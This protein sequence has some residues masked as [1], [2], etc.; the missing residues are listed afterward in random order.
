MERYVRGAWPS[1]NAA[2]VHPVVEWGTFRYV[3]RKSVSLARSLVAIL[4][5]PVFLSHC[6]TF[7]TIFSANPLVAGW[8]G[9]DL[10]SC[11]DRFLS[12]V[13]G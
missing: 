3:R 4:L 11:P 1:S 8:Y 7:L 5:P 10:V 9:V 6:F 12:F 2:G 13:L